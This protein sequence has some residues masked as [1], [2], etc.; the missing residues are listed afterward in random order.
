MLT[1]AV[2]W[3]I[4][5]PGDIHKKQNLFFNCDTLPVSQKWF[6]L[7]L[8]ES[9]YI[10]LDELSY[11]EVLRPVYGQIGGL[12]KSNTYSNN[13][14]KYNGFC[15]PKCLIKASTIWF[16]CNTTWGRVKVTGISFRNW[17][18]PSVRFKT[19]HFCKH[20]AK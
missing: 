10:F 15:S 14:C 6:I 2:F 18:Y 17:V 5:G 1:K 12:L 20:S 19:L 16:F 8:R 4:N 13:G 9:F 11:P 3:T 7:K